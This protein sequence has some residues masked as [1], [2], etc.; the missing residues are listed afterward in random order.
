MDYTVA[1]GLS[2]R[3]RLLLEVHNII[4]FSGSLMFRQSVRNKLNI[5]LLLS[6]VS[7]VVVVV[8]GA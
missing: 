8:V 4:I 7:V 1:L 2:L 6:L 3:R 5:I